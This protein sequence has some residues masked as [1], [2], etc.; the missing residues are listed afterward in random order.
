MTNHLQLTNTTKKPLDTIKNSTKKTEGAS[1]QQDSSLKKLIC[2][3]AV[4]SSGQTLRSSETC[5][6]PSVLTLS[7]APPRSQTPLAPARA[8]SM[9]RN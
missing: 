9:A 8:G 1:S 4:P 2:S 3:T 5:G 6:V 7:R